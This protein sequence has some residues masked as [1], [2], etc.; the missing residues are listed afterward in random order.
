[1]KGIY[2]Y[3][4]ETNHVSR[5]Y[6]VA[7][8]LWLQITACVTTFPCR[9]FCT[10]TLALSAVRVQRIIWLF[11]C[12]LISCFP[13]MLLRYCL[14][15]RWFHFPLIITGITLL[16]L[17]LSSSSSL[18]PLCRVFIHIFLRQTMSLGNTVFQQFYH[19]YLG[20][21]VAS[22]CVGSIVLLR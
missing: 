5:V 2:N 22:S 7:T 15:C 21:Y 3:I 9:T 10:S 17:S 18:S 12:Y 19:Y 11:C 1:M 14:I 4:T 6:S 20:A 16:L 13:G 8:T